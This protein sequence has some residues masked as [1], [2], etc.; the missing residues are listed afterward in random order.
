MTDVNEEAVAVGLLVV[1][2]SAVSGYL[3]YGVS[4]EAVYSEELGSMET[5]IAE[6]DGEYFSTISTEIAAPATYS[7][8]PPAPM[9]S[10]PE[11]GISVNL[12][13]QMG[14]QI[15]KKYLVYHQLL[16]KIGTVLAESR[17]RVDTLAAV[18]EPPNILAVRSVSDSRANILLRLGSYQG[19]P[20]NKIKA[21]LFK[22]KSGTESDEIMVR[23]IVLEKPLENHAS[24]E[25]FSFEIEGLE[26][27][28]QYSLK[29]SMWNKIGKSN[30]S[31]V[32]KFTQGDVPELPQQLIALHDHEENKLR[33]SWVAGD[34]S[35]KQ[36]NFLKFK[37]KLMLRPVDG[38]NEELE[39]ESIELPAEAEKI[40]VQGTETFKTAGKLNQYRFAMTIDDVHKHTDLAK[41][42]Q[43]FRNKEMS[44]NLRFVVTLVATDGFNTSKSV[45]SSVVTILNTVSLGAMSATTFLD[46]DAR[47]EQVE[48]PNRSVTRTVTLKTKL[49]QT[50]RAVDVQQLVKDNARNN[51]DGIPISPPPTKPEITWAHKVGFSFELEQRKIIRA[52]DGINE[53]LDFV[54]TRVA[55]SFPIGSLPTTEAPKET[56]LVTSVPFGSSERLALKFW[57]ENNDGYK[58]PSHVHSSELPLVA[59]A[60]VSRLDPTSFSVNLGLISA[61]LFVSVGTNTQDITAKFF[62]RPTPAIGQPPEDFTLSPVQAVVS[63][64]LPNIRKVTYD[65]NL[66][67]V[68]Q[69]LDLKLA[70]FENG[71]EIY[72]DSNFTTTFVSNTDMSTVSKD[73]KYKI[74]DRTINP[75]LASQ[76]V[77]LAY[78]SKEVIVEKLKSYLNLSVSRA[79][80]IR[81]T[82]SD[83]VATI[84]EYFSSDQSNKE[85]KMTMSFDSEKLTGIVR[86]DVTAQ[87]FKDDLL[88]NN[89]R[90]L[91]NTHIFFYLSFSDLKPSEFAIGASVSRVVSGQTFISEVSEVVVLKDCFGFDTG[92]LS[93]DID[94]YG[95]AIKLLKNGN[96]SD[97][98][99]FSAYVLPEDGAGEEQPSIVSWVIPQEFLV[100]R[101]NTTDTYVVFNFKPAVQGVVPPVP[102][103]IGAVLV[104]MKTV[105]IEFSN[106]FKLLTKTPEV[107]GSLLRELRSRLNINGGLYVYLETPSGSPA[108][109][110]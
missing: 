37:A 30:I 12:T 39:V 109:N 79:I 46:L 110:P 78:I 80:E 72:R 10:F 43:K 86:A 19:S 54:T 28:V 45:T 90:S 48:G 84:H 40:L 8:A 69:L 32:I 85:N 27:G 89:L 82:V 101:I 49:K 44:R 14:L 16:S 77:A 23:D 51:P 59:K 18:P 38:S 52:P 81:S 92:A 26:K 63:Q 5:T 25:E 67:G 15:G 7:V 35:D 102:F 99:S 73:I 76:Y 98:V 71:Q 53:I 65:P 105:G 66:V 9:F 24:G 55:D 36:T 103:K 21:Y 31:S 4:S 60:L 95:M 22:D 1:I 29:L 61:G 83:K 104:I 97:S 3:T 42:Q 88:L 34:D 13:T 50:I 33:V 68:S 107:T 58:S 20:I 87:S 11:G 94:D 6:A 47:G 75:S 57:L 62:R 91:E 74:F 100:T 56:S 93:Y 108:A 17:S 106:T 70:V 64:A 2:F 41:L 96:N